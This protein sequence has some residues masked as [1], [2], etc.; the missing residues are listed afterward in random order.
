MAFCLFVFSHFDPHLLYCLLP[1]PDLAVKELYE[2]SLTQWPSATKTV[3][4]TSVDQGT[5]MCLCL[6]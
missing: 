5:G 4:W 2:F 1:P 3:I 6:Y